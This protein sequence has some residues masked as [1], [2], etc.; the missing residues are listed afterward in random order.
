MFIF[1]ILIAVET[2]VI[3]NSCSA[4][5]DEIIFPAN[6][7]KCWHFNIYEQEKLHYRLI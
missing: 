7:N 5:N 4:E 6:G 2:D 1:Y 3:K